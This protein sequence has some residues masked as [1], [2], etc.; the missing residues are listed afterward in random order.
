M[1][2]SIGGFES[3]AYSIILLLTNDL[4]RTKRESV[5]VNVPVLKVFDWSG[6][7]EEPREDAFFPAFFI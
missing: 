4:H 7:K 2:P 5:Q 6:R 3:A 1:M